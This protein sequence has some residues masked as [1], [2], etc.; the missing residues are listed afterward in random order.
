MIASR[1]WTWGRSQRAAA[2]FLSIQLVDVLT[3]I[4]GL[5]AGGREVGLDGAQLTQGFGYLIKMAIV[6][7]IALRILDK[8]KLGRISELAAYRFLLIASCLAMIGPANNAWQLWNYYH[9]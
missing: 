4:V 5:R 9:G 7:L 1:G 2:L 8:V 6:T 3:T